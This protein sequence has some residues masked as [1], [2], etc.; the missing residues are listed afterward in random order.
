HVT[1]LRL[2]DRQRGERA[3]LALHFSIR[4]LLDVRLVHARGALEQTR[5]QIEHVARIRLAARRA[6]QQQRYLA[7]RPGLLGEIVVDDQ[8]VFAVVAEVLAHRTA[9]VRRDE[10]HRRRF[11]RRG[12]DD[13][14]VR[15]RAVLLE[16]AHDVG[17]RAGLLADRD[18]N[19][20]NA[21]VLL[22]D[23]RID[24]ERGLAGLAV[25]DDQL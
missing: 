11:R 3:G 9:R 8:G 12:R 7:I 23:D 22:I 5:V 17:D 1:G 10:L 15:H 13:D 4:E 18:V 6:A 19:A 24:R 21:R 16:L 14:G 25:A 20:L 2:D